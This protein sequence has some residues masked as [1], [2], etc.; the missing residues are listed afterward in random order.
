MLQIIFSSFVARNVSNTVSQSA[1]VSGKCG[2]FASFFLYSQ[3]FA[4]VHASVGK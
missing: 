3:D 2:D 1:V 4:R